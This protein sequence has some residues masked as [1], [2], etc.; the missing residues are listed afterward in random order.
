MVGVAVEGPTLRLAVVRIATQSISIKDPF[1]MKDCIQ[2]VWL[3]Y[4]VDYL[5]V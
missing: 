3:C 4:L 5:S 2:S 1:A